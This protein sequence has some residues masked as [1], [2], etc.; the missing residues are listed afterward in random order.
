MP[1][2]L[3]STLYFPPL[4]HSTREGLLA[5]GG[6]LRVERL[7]LAYSRGIFPW[8]DD[9]SPI[10][11]WAPPERCILPLRTMP[12]ERFSYDCAEKSV[13]QEAGAAQQGRTLGAGGLRISQRLAR[14]YK[15]PIFRHT[16]N[17]AFSA[18]IAQCAAVPRPGQDGTWITQD[19]QEAYIRLH[20]VGYAH[21][22]E[23]WQEEELIGGLY[24]VALGKVFFGESMFHVQPDGSKMALMTL[25]R[26]L[27]QHDFQL[28]D[29]QQ[30]TAHMLRMGAEVISR[31]Q[32]DFLLK[33]ILE[34]SGKGISSLAQSFAHKQ[35][36]AEK[37]LPLFP[38]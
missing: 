28:L 18:V 6:D 25:V 30:A 9:S 19:M 36:L 1:L 17:T 11:W 24:G 31:E 20:E 4:H 29:C 26:T 22:V 33:Q 12:S 8:Y 32:F 10:L 13:L 14:K 21:S 3:N 38:L 34:M 35:R 16:I 7:V 23:C 15:Q 37:K 5:V 27:L 2:V